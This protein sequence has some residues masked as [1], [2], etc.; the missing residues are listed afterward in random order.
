[1]L[2]CGVESFKK[3]VGNVLRVCVLACGVDS[4]NK[5]VGNVVRV[6]VLACGVDSANKAVGNVVR[7][8]GAS[9]GALRL[10]A[11]ASSQ[12]NPPQIETAQIAVVCFKN[13]FISPSRAK[14]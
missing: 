12:K 6:G 11:K 10:I 3:A 7:W 4:A 9:A 8:V 13:P 1:V 2:A 14:R 5:A